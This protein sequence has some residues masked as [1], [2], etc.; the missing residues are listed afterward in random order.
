ML[1]DDAEAGPIIDRSRVYARREQASTLRPD[2]QFSPM[3][4]TFVDGLSL[5]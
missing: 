1:K 2:K 3:L 4:E 5:K